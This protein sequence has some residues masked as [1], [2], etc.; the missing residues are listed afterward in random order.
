MSNASE[1]IRLERHDGLVIMTLDRP[2]VLNA[3]NR[4][5][6]DQIFEALTFE[7][8]TPEVRVLLVE[9]SGRAFGSGGD[10]SEFGM[11]GS[12][13]AA[14]ET[15]HGCR[16][17]S[18][19]SRDGRGGQGRRHTCAAYRRARRICQAFMVCCARKSP[20]VPRANG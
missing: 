18:A 8:A 16:S 20:I 13:L 10:L 1:V 17:G 5:M 6:R 11:A 12:P 7:A 19:A 3:Y 2:E 15:R 9:G 14:R 4:Q